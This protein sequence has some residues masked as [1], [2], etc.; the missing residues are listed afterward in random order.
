MNKKVTLYD[1]KR[2]CDS[3]ESCNNCP[4][5]LNDELEGCSLFNDI[6]AVNNIVY[7]WCIKHPVKGEHDRLLQKLQ[8]VRVETI[9]EFVERLKIRLHEDYHYLGKF[10]FETYLDNFAKEMVEVKENEKLLNNN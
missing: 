1:F 4:I 10:A 7:N 5:L 8:Q 9:K 3:Y 2:M 6:N